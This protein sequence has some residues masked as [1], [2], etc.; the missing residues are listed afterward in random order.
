MTTRTALVVQ[1]DPTTAYLLVRALT[2][3]G[4]AV[5][6]A[7]DAEQAWSAVA[8]GEVPDLV[9]LDNSLPGIGALELC[10]R[11]KQRLGSPTHVV[12]IAGDC[13]EICVARSLAAGA[14]QVIAKPFRLEELQAG[15]GA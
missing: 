5:R 6:H 10:R 1:D 15:V 8:A 3:W 13:D 7:G 9:V 12:L 11:I 2:R 4:F 14:G